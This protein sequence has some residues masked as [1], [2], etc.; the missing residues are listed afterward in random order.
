MRLK[1]IIFIVLLQ[2]SIQP[3]VLAQHRHQVQLDSIE[4]KIE[5]LK[6]VY[7]CTSDKSLFK[8]ISENAIRALIRRD[9][10]Y[11]VLNRDQSAGGAGAGITIDFNSD[12][13]VVTYNAAFMNDSEKRKKKKLL[14]YPLAKFIVSTS[15]TAGF[16]NSIGNLFS[17]TKADPKAGITLK[18]SYLI[19][20]GTGPSMDVTNCGLVVPATKAFIDFLKTKGLHEFHNWDTRDRLITDKQALVAAED[21]KIA[22]GATGTALVAILETKRKLL[23]SIAALQKISMEEP[24]WALNVIQKAIDSLVSYELKEVKWNKQTVTWVDLQAGVNANQI[25]LF[26][27]V[28]TFTNNDTTIAK[29]NW[30]FNIN[31]I[32]NWQKVLWFVRFGYKNSI[33]TNIDNATVYTLDDAEVYSS[34]TTQ[35]KISKPVNAYKLSETKAF[36]VYRKHIVDAESIFMFAKNRIGIHGFL[37]LNFNYQTVSNTKTGVLNGGLGIIFTTFNQAKDKVKLNIE[38]FFKL[39][40]INAQTPS[41]KKLDTWERYTFGIRV[42]LP[43]NRILL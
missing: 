14:D 34:G 8:V 28:S 26:D 9:F 15:V 23:E 2:L 29:N 37:D 3:T 41:S 11:L 42:G 12:N 32:Q 6:T 19:S 36:E 30:G 40:D 18:L 33:A 5:A 39:K 10:S 22:A 43:F 17:N 25:N 20:K 7:D 13:T 24:L 35:R 16:S 31:N 1:K 4:N 38:P 27:N 21:A